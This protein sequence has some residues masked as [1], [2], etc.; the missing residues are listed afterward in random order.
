MQIHSSLKFTLWVLVGLIAQSCL[1][2]PEM[3]APIIETPQAAEALFI[4]DGFDFGMTTDQA[5][6]ISVHDVE[7]KPIGGVLISFYTAPLS[8]GGV[9]LG[10]GI[11]DNEGVLRTNFQVSKDKQALYAYTGFTSLAKAQRLEITG[12]PII[13]EW[14][15]S[16][17]PKEGSVY[18]LGDKDK[19]FGCETGLFQVMS[20]RLKKLN[21]ATGTYVTL[22]SA[23]ANY[24]G[25]GFNSEDN[26]I[27]ATRK[28]NGELR[29]WKIDNTGQETDLG[30]VEGLSP[31]GIN[32][33]GD[34]DLNGNLTLSGKQGNWKLVSID[35]DQQPITAVTYD[36]TQ[37]GS[38]YLYGFADITFNLNQEKFYAL[39][40]RCNFIEID[41]VAKTIRGLANYES[42]IGRGSFGALWSSNDEIYVS[43][44]QDGNIY[45]ITLDESGNPTGASFIMQGEPSGSNDGASCTQAV[46]P[47]L[48]SDN[49]GIIDTYDA[50]P[51]DPDRAYV[52]FSPALGSNGTYAFED[53]WPKAG[54]YDFNDL[55]LD[56]NYE[57]M[58]NAQ[59]KIAKMRLS[60]TLKSVGATFEIGFGLSFDK[61]WGS[62]IA[63][64]KGIR[65]RK[66]SKNV[67]GTEANQS[68]AVVI[69]FDDAHGVLN[70]SAGRMLNNGIGEEVGDV[71]FD[72]EIY[73]AN[74]LEDIGTIN[75]FIFT[76]GD[77][78]REIHLKGQAPTDLADLSFFGT[79]DDG[80][81]G[82]DTYMTKSG[83]PWALNFPESFTPPEERASL[84]EVY[85]KFNA[86]VASN[87]NQETMWYSLANSKSDKLM[88]RNRQRSEEDGN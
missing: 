76:Q 25:M 55:I 13:H 35:V 48:D 72:V 38:S 67:N 61:L 34:F 44:N 18:R 84:T 4:P 86:W 54:D 74:P 3:E 43:K 41:P 11:T 70:R 68:N 33:I 82:N 27:Y 71:T 30:V 40:S 9:L 45:K 51:N 83:M 7:K 16:P 10:N 37:I 50:Y 1:E 87:G 15:S 24:N 65:T 20:G 56:Y 39:D 53:Q 85:P 52:N 2:P 58:K 21:V 64:V 26:F 88:K 47:F 78:G 36:L 81:S 49:D 28:T 46:S 73:F 22:G 57:F 14:G 75:P 31:N 69:I 66:I 17:E 23:S 19:S 63:Q 79:E 29:I 59:N 6:A 5:I 80:S 77:R 12:G 8:Q 60:Y 32:Y 62:D 42:V